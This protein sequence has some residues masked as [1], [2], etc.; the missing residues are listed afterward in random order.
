MSRGLAGNET[1]VRSLA[2][3]VREKGKDCCICGN[4]NV[5]I[6]I[7]DGGQIINGL[8]IFARLFCREH[9]EKWKN[10]ETL[11]YKKFNGVMLIE[12]PYQKPVGMWTNMSWSNFE[13]LVET[14]TK[15]DRYEARFVPKGSFEEY[16]TKNT[17]LVFKGKIEDF[18]EEK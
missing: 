8:M 17:H 2:I 4:E 10:G 9:D 7:F 6:W 16:L 12:M 11:D 18:L 13:E 14:H 5:S 3:T 1:S 15:D